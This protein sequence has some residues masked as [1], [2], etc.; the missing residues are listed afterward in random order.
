[1]DLLIGIRRRLKKQ[2]DPIEVWDISAIRNWL[3]RM[4]SRLELGKTVIVVPEIVIRQLSD[5]GKVVDVLAYNYILSYSGDKLYYATTATEKR[6][7]SYNEQILSIQEDYYNKGYNVT[8]VTC[9]TIQSHMAE[10]RKLGCLLFVG[11][12]PNKNLQNEKTQKNQKKV[13]E[14]SMSKVK[15]KQV[16]SVSPEQMEVKNKKIGK[17][18]HILTRAGVEVYDN[19]GKR[20]IG[21]NSLV[22]VQL[23]ERVVYDGTEYIVTAATSETVV[24]KRI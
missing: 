14:S 22:K 10:E 20:R 4:Q 9:N 24:L 11:N 7:M 21:K 13:E 1:M 17:D 8:L 2:K 6:D 16:C 15:N 12:K 5:S 18:N 23:M 19:R 3:D